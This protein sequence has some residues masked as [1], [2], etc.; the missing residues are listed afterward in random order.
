VI[1][2]QNSSGR[3]EDNRRQIIEAGGAAVLWD[4][5]MYA[6]AISV[7]KAKRKEDPTYPTFACVAIGALNSLVQSFPD[8]VYEVVDIEEL[9]TV[10]DDEL[11]TYL[12]YMEVMAVLSVISHLTYY[13]PYHGTNPTKRA[14]WFARVSFL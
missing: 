13:D 8:K 1:A 4:F 12:S 3:V 5:F 9:I 2:L 6:K 10:L 14:E 11:A 7:R